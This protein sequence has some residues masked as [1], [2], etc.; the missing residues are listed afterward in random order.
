MS[1]PPKIPVPGAI[2]ARRTWTSTPHTAAGDAKGPGSRLYVH[3]TES[4]GREL[5]TPTREA[6]ALRAIREYHVNGR[7]WDDIGYSYLICQPWERKGAAAIYVG[8]GA[9]RI[10]ASQQGANRGHWSVAVVASQNEHIMDR[11]LAA[12]AW[13]AQ[14]L[15]PGG[16]I[17]PH[18][19]QNATDCPGDYIRAHMDQIRHWAA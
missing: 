10:P 19:A 4:P 2:H 3:I 14:H 1:L 17:L 6:A 12:I 15:K 13:L 16:G 18:S 8:R 9:R 5:T 11:T 7:G